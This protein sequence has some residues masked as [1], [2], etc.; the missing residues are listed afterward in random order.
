[1]NRSLPPPDVLRGVLGMLW[2]PSFGAV[3]MISQE[4]S[5][6]QKNRTVHVVLNFASIACATEEYYL[7]FL[8]LLVS[9]EY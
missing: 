8:L 9:T 7:R 5:W 3:D 4:A 6:R 2:D 1:M